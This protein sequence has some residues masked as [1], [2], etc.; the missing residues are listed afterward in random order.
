MFGD[1][2]HGTLL[3]F[4]ALAMIAFE[5]RILKNRRSNEVTATSL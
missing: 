5:K 2:G 3:V 4:A 1:A